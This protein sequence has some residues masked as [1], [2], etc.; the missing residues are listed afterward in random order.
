MHSMFR[1]WDGTNQLRA[2]TLPK[3]WGNGEV[4]GKTTKDS[5]RVNGNQISYN[6]YWM[7]IFAI[8]AILYG[9]SKCS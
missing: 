3:L 2:K 1:L 8:I 9:L 5:D 7:A 4:Y 6:T